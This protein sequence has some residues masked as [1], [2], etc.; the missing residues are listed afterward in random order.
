M[1]YRILL[2]ALFSLA[3]GCLPIAAQT[4]ETA[5]TIKIAQGGVL[6]GVAI[7]LPKPAYPTTAR[8]VGASG[9]VNVQVTIDERGNVISANAISGHPLLRAVASDAAKQ[10][11]FKPTLLSSPA[12]KISGIIVYNFVSGNNSSADISPAGDQTE[13]IRTPPTITSNSVINAKALS[14]P[15]PEYSPAAIAVNAGGVINVRVTLNEEGNVESAEAVSGHPLLQAAS[16]EAAKQAKF[17]PVIVSGKPAK[18][19]GIIVYNFARSETFL[20]WRTIGYEM[21]VAERSPELPLKFPAGSISIS[22]PESW[23]DERAEILKLRAL[24]NSINNSGTARGQF[25]SA[26]QTLDIASIDHRQVIAGLKASFENRLSSQPNDLWNFSL[27]LLLGKI[28]RQIS[29]DSALRTNLAELIQLGAN[30]PTDPAGQL[31]LLSEFANKNEFS[32]ADK[33]RIWELVEKLKA[34]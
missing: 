5:N 15:R 2:A 28:S 33:V 32:A 12:L 6:N 16:V 34:N 17:Q 18:V 22:F 25:V 20:N 10:A 4:N 24:Q 23:N 3:L 1:K 11:K 14:L 8:A 9:A 26:S 30:A 27:G 29:D 13:N 21:A 7:S 19:S 31:N